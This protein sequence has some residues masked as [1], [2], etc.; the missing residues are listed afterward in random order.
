[1]SINGLLIASG[2]SSRI[3][4][5]KP[6]LKY[7]GKTFL[8]SIVEKMLTELENVVIV[9]GYEHLLLLNEFETH[10]NCTLQKLNSKCWQI[11]SRITI[12]LNEDY[13]NGM[14]TS[15]QLGVKQL[16]NSDWILYHF[17]DQP[18]IPNEFYGELTKRV[19]ADTNFIQPLFEG[20]KG[21]PVLFDKIVS[22][23]IIKAKNSSNFREVLHDKTIEKYLWECKYPQVLEDID[24]DEDYLKL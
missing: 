14:F 3:D 21:H 8:I 6:L 5:F 18:T 17:V 1:M 12:L 16:R 20:R 24:T 2:L 10:F 15:L 22:S 11:N 19:K 23:K 4:G 7:N 13:Q 9:V